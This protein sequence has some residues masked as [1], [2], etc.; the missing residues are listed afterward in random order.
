MTSKPTHSTRLARLASKDG[1]LSYAQALELVKRAQ[2]EKRL[3]AVLD[4]NGMRDALQILARMKDEAS[5]K[6]APHLA[7]MLLGRD[8]DSAPFFI[9]A[10]ALSTHTMILGS[11]G[12]GRSVA[13][14]NFI[15]G[16][17][18]LGWSGTVLDVEGDASSGGLMEFCKTAASAHTLAYQ[19]VSAEVASQSRLNSLVGLGPD[20]ARDLILSLVPFDDVYWQNVNKKLLTQLVNLCYDAFTPTPTKANPTILDIGTFLEQPGL[21]K[22]TAHLVESVLEI[23]PDADLS[24]YAAVLNP[25]EDAQK[26]AV[27]LGAALTMLYDTQSSRRVLD[28]ANGA[29][30]FDY[31]AP[32]LS[33]VGID[34]SSHQDLARLVSGTVLAH[35][36]VS[37]RQR[38][39]AIPKPARRFL[40][41]SGAASVDHSHLAA[42]LSKARAGAISVVL[43]EQSP[44]SF[45]ESSFEQLSQNI[46]VTVM[47]AQ[48]QLSSAERSAA[49]LDDV[50]TANELRQ[51]MIG[52]ALV[53]VVLP[54]PVITRVFISAS[55]P[56]AVQK[57]SNTPGRLVAVT[58]PVGGAGRTTVAYL[59]AAALAKRLG[60]RKRICLVD[61]DINGPGLAKLTGQYTPDVTRLVGNPAPFGL[62]AT[63]KEV[64]SGPAPETLVETIIHRPDIGFDLLLGP[65]LPGKAR[66]VLADPAFYAPVLAQ[67]T[68]DYDY[69]I[70]DTP[71]A[72]TQEA[73]LRDAVLAQAYY[74][75][76]VTTLKISALLSVDEWLRGISAA[77]GTL[78]GLVLNRSDEPS[79][80]TAE[81][82]AREMARIPIISQI[83]FSGVWATSPHTPTLPGFGLEPLV[84]DALDVIVEK[85]SYR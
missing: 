53:R 35:A 85:V 41:I 8:S 61:A 73:L 13:F 51:L 65:A 70:V 42:L 7:R 78:L 57:R 72:N 19:Q 81:D 12:S 71:V 30:E 31:D 37:A 68:L 9:D 60:P 44:L 66:E 2:A 26:S 14:Q 1:D 18:D 40:A 29:S 32:G 22:A 77:S 82:A 83:P 20:E 69:V 49:L 62:D 11:T 33:Y 50:P 59:L 5:Y 39:S 36:N 46:N 21:A 63:T 27:G 28:A 10:A 56:A 4:D 55:A 16:M 25:T 45:E 15:S 84:I 54:S 80:I 24:R 23:R 6:A 43:S 67:L 38:F 75:L 48:S 74:T 3:P 17:L 64:R 52:E 76:V 47:M 58:S 79:A 34:A